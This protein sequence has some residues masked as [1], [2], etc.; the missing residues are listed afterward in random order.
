MTIQ[1][2][3]LSSALASTVAAII[4]H[5]ALAQA[6]DE[7]Q[8]L[9][10][11]D[12]NT[13]SVADDRSRVEFRLPQTPTAISHSKHYPENLLSTPSNDGVSQTE[14]SGSLEAIGDTHTEDSLQ[15]GQI[16]QT[17]MAVITDV[18]ISSTPE[19]LTVI[20]ISD[21]PLSASAPQVSGNALV[22]EIPNATL[23]LVDAAAA[24]QFGPAEGIAL[25]Q[26]SS[27]PN[28]GV[29]VAITGTDAP[30]TA[31]VST[32]SGN[33]VLSVVPGIAAGVAEDADAIQVIVTATRTEEDVRDVP[34]SVT[35]IDREQIQQ[36]LLFNTSLPDILGRLV[37]GLSPPT[38]E[39]ST[40]G[41]RLRGRPIVVLIDGIPQTPNNN[42]FERSLST[43]APQ[44]IEQIEVLRGPSAIYGDGGTG[45]VI[46]I[47]TRR[48]SEEAIAYNFSIGGD[49]SL[50]SS[51][52]DRFGNEV[53]LGV[54][55][56][57][58]RADGLLSLSFDST[59]AQFE[60][61]G[62]RLAPNGVANSDRLG[63]L[64][65][66]GYNFDEQQRLAFTYSFYR[67]GQ[68]T[69][70]ITAP[71]GTLPADA[72]FGRA[73]FVGTR[74]E[75]APRQLNNVLNLTYS[76]AD[77]LSSQVDLQ[78]YY[79]N[80]DLVDIFTDL[81]PGFPLP[82]FPQVWQTTLNDTEWGGRLQIDTALGESASLLWGIDYTQ[83]ET[84]SPLFVNNTDASVTGF[85][86]VVDTSLDRFPSYSLNSLGVFAQATWDITE[87]FQI[88][89]GLRYENVDLSVEDYQIAFA[90]ALPRERQGGSSSFDDVSFNAGLLYRPIPEV[91]LFASFAQGFSIPNIGSSLINAP[92]G[93]DVATDLLLQP[94]KV[95]NYEVGIRVDLDQ[96]QG[97]ISGFY[98]ESDLGSAITLNANGLGVIQ[99]APQRNYGFEATLDWQP[100]DTLRLGALYSWNEGEND[101]DTDGVFESL[102]Q[103]EIQP[104]KFGFYIENDTLP[105]WT[106]RL[107]LL[108]VGVRI[109]DLFG[110][111]IAVGGYTVVDFSSSIQLGGGRLTLGLSNLFNTQY[112]TARQ[113]ARG[114]IGQIVP[115][116]GRTL[117]LRYS[118]DF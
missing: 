90:F 95:D 28:G 21:Q 80:T 14:D 89:G 15:L 113:Q 98:S 49:M 40:L 47:I 111:D 53:E 63:L 52:G 115:N 66:L 94:Q 10:H 104:Q 112:I 20:L 64:A 68:G 81:G 114:N 61:G 2:R 100:M 30:P 116:P 22:T 41:L 82:L 102:S 35:V 12:T 67:Q 43:I 37:P 101:V 19:G 46:N 74:Y 71:G 62:I 110:D 1:I 5:P 23:G 83:N 29:Q 11:S 16:A 38:G 107:D 24:E 25:V 93:F 92:V 32:E 96:I 33:L 99:R 77:I 72:E 105:G 88:S 6:L 57:S 27:L 7:F 48:P 54:S 106:N 51:E 42:G 76:H 73:Q 97:T 109:G 8:S 44:Q 86:S 118:I 17:E 65:K 85:A 58:E 87:Q 34:R 59:A 4:A 31:Q 103:L 69:D 91:G 39:D 56:S 117:S 9:D 55:A 26:V 84:D 78:L 3:L 75:E 13:A 60:A 70:Y 50:S 45:G 108:L 79:R 18:Q 36:Q